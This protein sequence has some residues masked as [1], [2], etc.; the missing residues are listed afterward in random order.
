VLLAIAAV[1][2]A[3]VALALLLG[4]YSPECVEKLFDKSLKAFRL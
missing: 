2:A 3:G 4:A 1:L